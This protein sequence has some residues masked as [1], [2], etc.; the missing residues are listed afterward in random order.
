[1]AQIWYSLKK[2]YRSLRIQP[3]MTRLLGPQYRRSRDRIEIDITYRCNLRC[4]N[5]NRSIARAP[6]N[7]DIATDK[8]VEF[9]EDSLRRSLRWRRI[10][11]L[12]GEPTLHPQFMQIVELLRSYRDRGNLCSIEIVTN[13]YGSVVNRQLKQLPADI[14]V[15]NSRKKPGYQGGFRPF[16]MAP[17]DDPAYS[18]VCFINGCE[19]ISVCGMGLTP[20]GYYPCALSGGIDRIVGRH[21]G[22]TNLPDPDDDM[23][24]ILEWACPLCGRFKDGHHMPK[25][26]IPLLTTELI[27]PSWEQLYDEW[28]QR[29]QENTD[30]S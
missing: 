12:G 3:L 13:G 11:L 7:L 18:R 17:A 16:S 5:C 25:E 27:S 9:V 22:R 4:V 14:W 21:I 10:R 28:N 8:I 19:I 26:R 15:E 1:M 23:E 29:R 30:A 2:R 6:E 24:D 20:Q